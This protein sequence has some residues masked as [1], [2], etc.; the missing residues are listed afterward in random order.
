VGEGDGG[1][2]GRS[3]IHRGKSLIS[4]IGVGL[5]GVGGGAGGIP[6][7]TPRRAGRSSSNQD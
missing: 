1:G 7:P 4:I 6:P 5:G 2:A 3:S